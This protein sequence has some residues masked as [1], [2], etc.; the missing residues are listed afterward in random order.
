MQVHVVVSAFEGVP[1]G[2]RVYRNKEAAEIG[3]KEAKGNLEIE[4][5]QEAESENAA[6]LFYNVPVK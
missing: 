4:P 3:L 5:G 6:D 1:D 2:V